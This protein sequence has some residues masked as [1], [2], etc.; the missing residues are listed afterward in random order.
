MKNN[1]SDNQ[2]CI[3]S[4]SEHVLIVLFVINVSYKIN[5]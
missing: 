2:L 3:L 1:R 4:E 5:N